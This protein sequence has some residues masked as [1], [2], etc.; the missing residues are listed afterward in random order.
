MSNQIFLF[1]METRETQ[2]AKS[3]IETADENDRTVSS[4][5]MSCR[6]R[7]DSAGNL[8]AVI[9]AACGRAAVKLHGTLPVPQVVDALARFLSASLPTSAA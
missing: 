2:L 5:G 6:Y 3:I 1:S 4:G 8:L 9:D 7:F